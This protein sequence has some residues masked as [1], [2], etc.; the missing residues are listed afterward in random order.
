MRRADRQETRVRAVKSVLASG[1][2]FD[3]TV[4]SA[5]L[6]DVRPLPN[7]ARHVPLS[8]LRDGPSRAAFKPACAVKR[9]PQLQPDDDE[10]ERHP[11]HHEPFEPAGPHKHYDAEG[12]QREPEQRTGHGEPLTP[13]DPILR[14]IDAIPSDV[15]GRNPGRGPPSTATKR[16]R[17]AA[18][19]D[20]IRPSARSRSG[21]HPRRHR[22]PGEG[23]PGLGTIELPLSAATADRLDGDAMEARRG[24]ATCLIGYRRV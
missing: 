2:C 13:P 4:R 9:R 23:T 11:Q 22:L 16:A 19:T 14:H 18:A 8:T 15:W 10:T 7:L 3:G 12:Q 5:A 21:S 1:H 6:D 17:H 20:D 24:G